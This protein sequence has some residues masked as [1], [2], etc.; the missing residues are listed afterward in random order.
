MCY[1]YGAFYKYAFKER[2]NTKNLKT[3]TKKVSADAGYLPKK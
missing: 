3:K 1:L 2:S